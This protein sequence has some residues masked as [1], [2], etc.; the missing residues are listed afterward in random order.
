MQ[1]VITQKV[2]EFIIE[3]SI[4][5]LEYGRTGSIYGSIE[6]YSITD[7]MPPVIN[8]TLSFQVVT[9]NWSSLS[10][11]FDNIEELKRYLSNNCSSKSRAAQENNQNIYPL[12]D[13]ISQA[14]FKE[15][16]SKIENII[17]EKIIY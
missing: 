6:S 17:G 9:I 5:Y 10:H 8:L 16:H 14:D 2:K 1:V 13:S 15:L 4:L 12:E 3:S 11:K 7:M